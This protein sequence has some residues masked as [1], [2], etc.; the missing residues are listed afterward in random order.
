MAH[1]EVN[2]TK[3][4]QQIIFGIFKSSNDKTISADIKALSADYR[5]IILSKEITFPYFVLSR[6]Y[7]TRS[8]DFL[9][10]IGSDYE[11]DGLE[12]FVLPTGEYA[13]ITIKPKLGFIWGAAI[14]EAKT[15]FYT[16]WL[17]KSPYQALNMEYEYHTE[18]S[19][20]KNPT[21]DIIF[22]IE[23]MT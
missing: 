2:I 7:D 10:F 6:N 11:K 5:S 22:A 12:R 8:K 16:K 21:I 9:L 20:E 4:E 23:R 18:R 15:Y 13:K 1:L 17:P 19:T 3:I 14:G